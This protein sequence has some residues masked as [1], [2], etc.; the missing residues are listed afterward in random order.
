[1]SCAS[2]TYLRL[3]G[4]DDEGSTC[5][6]LWGVERVALVVLRGGV[7]GGVDVSAITAA[8]LLPLN[9]KVLFKGCLQ[10][11]GSIRSWS[12]IFPSSQS[13]TLFLSV[14]LTKPT[15]SPFSRACFMYSAPGAS[16]RSQARY[17]ASTEK[18]SDG[19]EAVVTPGFR[20]RVALDF[21]KD[22]DGEIRRCVAL[23]REE[24]GAS[25]LRYVIGVRDLIACRKLWRAS[26]IELIVQ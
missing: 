5:V 8:A 4:E 21:D 10:A 9:Y 24:H 26:I 11:R 17:T 7:P 16:L 22:I 19:P 3:V 12:A 14:T 13:T 1:M 6:G 20:Y 15:A 25:L 2:A 23:R 18:K